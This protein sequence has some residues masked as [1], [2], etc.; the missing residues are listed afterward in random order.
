[1]L[2]VLRENVKYLSW[3]LWVIIALFVLFIFADFGT[4]LGGNRQDTQSWAAKV[5]G[6]TISRLEYQRS[7]RV[8]ENQYRRQLADQYT[9][10]LAKQLQLPMRALDKA[11]TDR[12]LLREAERIGLKVS[13]AEVRDAILTEGAFHDDQGHFIGQEQYAQVLQAN[14]YTVAS[15]EDEVRQ[16][17]LKQKLASALRADLY[18]SDAEIEK[19]YRD[20]VERAKIRYIEVPRSRFGDAAVPQSEVAAYFQQHRQEYRLP[21]QREGAYLLVEGSKLLDQVKLTDADLQAYYQS[22]QDEWKQ[23]EQVHASH[24]LL[25]VNDKRTDAQARQQIDEI[26]KRLDNGEDFGAVARQVSED[27]G[28][29]ASGGDLGFFARGRM[30]KEFENAAF[31]ATPGRLVGPIK[32]P[33]GYHLLKVA[34]RRAA[35]V[36][37]FAEVREQIR[38]RLS[39]EKARQLAEARAKELARRAAADKPKSAAALQALAKDDPGV[40]FT[41]TGRFSQQDPV[42]G[43]GLVQQFNAAVFAAK[44]GE[45]TGAIEIPRGWAVAYVQAV[46]PGHLAELS[47][48]EPK[49][50]LALLSRKQQEKAVEA[51]NQARQ[52]IQHGKTFD[53]VA[54]ALAVPVKDTPE[55]GSTGTIPGLG[56]SPQL[57]KLALSLPAGQ[58][59]G[60]VADSRG[61]VLFLV[62]DRKSWEPAKFAAAKEQTRQSLQQQKLSSI[63]GALL[64]RRRRE[65]GVDYNR[66]LLESLGVSVDG[67]QPPQAG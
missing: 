24:I 62:T 6:D 31:S 47:E 56:P 33:F 9:P 51:L 37:P 8:M 52:E 20:Q 45:V 30:V 29:K 46:Y 13:D 14:G 1:M 16:D 42:P 44:T 57:T 36:Q 55:F 12:I 15:F 60:P 54:A 23:D 26:K 65:L 7:Y 59:G 10:A 53:Q 4:G 39:F 5:G 2:K 41:A 17:L 58:V 40:S 35:G 64:E 34:G 49:V 50:R 22:H 19:T 28:S 63:L 11:I 67:M 38:S 48:V 43:L 32:T 3:I 21:E 25:L 27:P 61:A 18:V 66:K